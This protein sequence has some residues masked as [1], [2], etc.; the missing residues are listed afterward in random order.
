MHVV[1]CEFSVRVLSNS[2]AACRPGGLVTVGIVLLPYWTVQRNTFAPEMRI[3]QADTT[4]MC[5]PQKLE[6][7]AHHVTQLA[8]PGSFP[9][10][11]HH[12]PDR[13]KSA[14]AGESA[15]AAPRLK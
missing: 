9:G 4:K 12:S 5:R 8:V 3:T 11:A 6:R 10:R 14:Q 15:A 1:L 13:C 7:W 2:S